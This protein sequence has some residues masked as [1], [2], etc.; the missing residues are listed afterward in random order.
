M[1][2][3]EKQKEIKRLKRLER[4]KLHEIKQ[5]KLKEI[6]KKKREKKMKQYLVQQEKDKELRK[7]KK[8]LDNQLKVNL[9]QKPGSLLGTELKMDVVE[10]DDL[11]F[12]DRDTFK[13]DKRYQEKSV[14][15]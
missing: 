9:S 7:Q 2:D 8:H 13:V 12:E 14:L 15:V 3:I 10:E 5:K 11:E 1:P 6:Y 4:E